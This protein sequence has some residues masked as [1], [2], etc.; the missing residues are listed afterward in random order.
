MIPS[1]PVV[2]RPAMRQD[3]LDL[4]FLHWRYPAEVIQPLLPSGLRVHTFDGSGWVGLVPFQMD[5]VRLAG[6]PALPWISRFPETNVRTYVTGPDGGHGIWFFSLDAARLPAVLCGRWGYALPY[7]WSSMAVR[8]DAETYRYRSARRWPGPRGARCDAVIARGAAVEPGPLEYF[9]TYRFRLFLER[10]K[11]IVSVLV[12]HAPWPLHTGRV[13]A[14]DETVV[15]A[16]GLPAPT[17][18]PLVHTSPGVSTR[19]GMGS[20]VAVATAS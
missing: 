8:V 16:A 11:R 19:I 20:R 1:S 15:A 12:D 6:V 3:W 2:R 17:G 7:V 5:R 14:L 18:D 4:T 13:L 9:L 10:R